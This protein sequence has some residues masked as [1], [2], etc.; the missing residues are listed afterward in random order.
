MSTQ[1]DAT[2]R[3]STTCV[4]VHGHQFAATVSVVFK[5]REMSCQPGTARPLLHSVEERLRKEASAAALNRFSSCKAVHAER[6]PPPDSS[7]SIHC[8][9]ALN[10]STNSL[11]PT[12]ST[13]LC[14]APS[15][16][17]GSNKQGLRQPAANSRAC[18]TGM[19]SSCKPCK[20]NTGQTTSRILSMFA[21]MS[22]GRVTCT[23]RATRNTDDMAL[24]KTNPFTGA[25]VAKLTDGPEPNDQP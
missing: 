7:S 12:E 23:G 13:S 22:P 24:C 19:V 2:E 9:K 20:I 21:N 17:K 1:A 14:P 16:Y 11:P 15:T 4:G 18:F 5:L 8:R 10:L 6:T 25:F 3:E